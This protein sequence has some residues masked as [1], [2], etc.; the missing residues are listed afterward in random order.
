MTWLVFTKAERDVWHDI[1]AEAK[2]K[3]LGTHLDLIWWRDYSDRVSTILREQDTSN[4]LDHEY[5]T[6]LPK[7]RLSRDSQHRS[8]DG[9]NWTIV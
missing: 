3:W 8:W 9:Y 4:A 1:V 5:K 7:Q 2:Y 6:N